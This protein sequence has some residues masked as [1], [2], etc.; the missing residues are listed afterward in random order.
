MNWEAIG[1]AGE[2]LGAVAVFVTLAYLANQIRHAREESR[3]ALSQART[4]ANREL[5]A[6][7]LQDKN[8]EAY[9]KADMAFEPE[10]RGGVEVL[11]SEAGLSRE[12][13]LRV[14][15]VYFAYWNYVVQIVPLV[16]SLG[17]SERGLFDGFIGNRFRNSGTYGKIYQAVTQKNNL[18]P[19]VIT[20]VDN[21]LRELSSGGLKAQN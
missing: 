14:M 8:L 4:E 1:A 18:Q 16:E 21:I 11:M 20:Y 6:L 9:L 17:E 3:R 10:P 7:S 15:N 2:V 13:A 19:E 5:I 12:E